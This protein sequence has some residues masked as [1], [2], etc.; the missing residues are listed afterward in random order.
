M[1]HEKSSDTKILESVLSEMKIGDFISY[2]QLSKSIGRDVRKFA[3]GALQTARLAMQRD[4]K[5][6]FGVDR[7]S[8]LRRLNDEQI[9]DAS[10]LGR[11]KLQRTAKR[12][13]KKLETVEFDKLTEPTKRK[14]IAASA[15]MGVIAMFSGKSS[16]KRIEKAVESTAS[17]LA[18]G[19][20]LKLFS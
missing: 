13:I 17:N 8:G 3:I 10:E 2:E 1:L 15:Q 19:E 18:I 7:G 6:V 20:T 11:R 14:H 5:M 16:S 4:H 12:E 9:V